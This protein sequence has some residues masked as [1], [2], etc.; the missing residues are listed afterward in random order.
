MPFKLF[1]KNSALFPQ[2]RKQRR[3][4][5]VLIGLVLATLLVVYF[6][7]WRSPAPSVPEP[8]TPPSTIM[9]EEIEF[10]EDFFNDPRFEGLELYG[11]WPL[12]IGET[13]RENPFLPY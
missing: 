5:L 4:M 6:V 9:P 1:S 11:Q 10:D 3:L 7:F 12:I 8:I 2:E 13:G